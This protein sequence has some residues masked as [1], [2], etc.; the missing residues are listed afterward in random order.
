MEK[1]FFGYVRMN[2]L[3][4]LYFHAFGPEYKKIGNRF[5]VKFKIPGMK[6]YIGLEVYFS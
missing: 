4:L 3:R 2:Y 5:V 1:A 6:Y